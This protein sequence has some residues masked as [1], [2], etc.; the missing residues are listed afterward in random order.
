M[1]VQNKLTVSGNLFDIIHAG[2]G[3]ENLLQ[4]LAGLLANILPSHTSTLLYGMENLSWIRCMLQKGKH[5][6]LKKRKKKSP[7][8]CS[9]KFG[10]FYKLQCSINQLINF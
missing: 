3:G 1:P 9:S 5:L 7:I 4:N 6:F 8:Q 10:Y 2:R